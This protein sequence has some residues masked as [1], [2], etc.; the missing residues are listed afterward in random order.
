VYPSIATRF[1][2][3]HQLEATEM[4]ETFCPFGFGQNCLSKEFV[5]QS[6][7]EGPMSPLKS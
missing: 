5:Q 2:V 1:L 4:F 6:K 3:W 7:K